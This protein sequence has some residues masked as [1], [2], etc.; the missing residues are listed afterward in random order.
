MS[1]LE[2]VWFYG[3]LQR[4]NRIQVPVL[5]R[6]RFRLQAGEV[7]R[8][9]VSDVGFGGRSVVFFARLQN[10]GRIT[11]PRAEAEVLEVKAG[12]V[13]KVGLLAEKTNKK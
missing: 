13:L 4:G 1:V 7:L 3:R 10:G 12:N 11:V 8:V 6:W 5:V 9:K 2:D